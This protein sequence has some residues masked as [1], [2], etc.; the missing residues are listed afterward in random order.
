M[1]FLHVSPS[2]LELQVEEDDFQV[3]DH[4]QNSRTSPSLA[5]FFCDLSEAA[6]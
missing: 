2:E 3:P 6:N 1:E 4:A 5:S